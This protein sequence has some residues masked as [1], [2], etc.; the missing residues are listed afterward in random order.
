MMA[1]PRI[2]ADN[3][4]KQKA[5]RARRDS[6]DE[7]VDHLLEALY[8]ACERG[9]SS[10]LMDRLPDEPRQKLIEIRRR[11]EQSKVIV[12]KKGSR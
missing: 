12:A 6:T 9:R 1:R 7:L 4:E 10:K 8:Q 3:A 5:Y 11:L 2:Y